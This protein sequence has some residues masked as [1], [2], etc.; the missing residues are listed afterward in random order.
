M[1]NYLIFGCQGQ[2]GQE[3]Q[4]RIG[5]RVAHFVDRASVDIT[6]AVAVAEIVSRLRPGV[7]INAAAYTAVDKAE[8]EPDL[9]HAV[10][11]EAP[12]YL[13]RA[14]AIHGA[15]LLHLSTDYVFDGSGTRPWREDDP[16]NPLS[17]YGATKAAGEAAVRATLDRHLILRTAW[18]VSPFRG[19]FVK[20]MLR[21]AAERDELRVVDDQFGGPTMAADIAVTA[22]ALADRLAAGGAAEHFGTFHYAGAPYV[23]WYA[24]AQSIVAGAKAYGGRQPKVTPIGTPDYPTPARRPANSRL[25]CSKL[26]RIHGIAAPDWRVALAD[27]LAELHQTGAAKP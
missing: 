4:R 23:S 1:N 11:A 17:V 13:A 9:A 18:V 12:G 21:L 14:C 27:L 25:D 3:L 24:F 10:N 16:I 5:S 7:V 8:S 26:A 2:V 22:L 20:T 15:V 19:N 6:D